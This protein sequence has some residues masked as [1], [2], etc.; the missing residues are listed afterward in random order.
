M[1]MIIDKG[2]FKFI[3]KST[4]HIKNTP[5]YLVTKKNKKNTSINHSIL[6]QT[7]NFYAVSPPHK[8]FTKKKSYFKKH[9]KNDDLKPSKITKKYQKTKK[10]KT[11]RTFEGSLVQ[12][13]IDNNDQEVDDENLFMN[14]NPNSNNSFIVNNNSKTTFDTKFSVQNKSKD[15]ISNEVSKN[16]RSLTPL[17]N[18]INNHY[19]NKA[20]I[21]QL[22]DN[23]LSLEN[24]IIDK[25]YENDIDHDEIIISSNNR[26]KSTDNIYNRNIQNDNNL[27]NMIDNTDINKYLN[28]N[29]E[30]NTNENLLNSSFENHKTDYHLMYV[31]NYQ[32]SVNDDILDLEIKLLYDKSLELQSYYHK[33]LQLLLCSYKENKIILKDVLNNIKYVKKLQNK[34]NVIRIKNTSK[35]IND[36]II[37]FEEKNNFS[38]ITKNN[39]NEIQIWN[40]MLYNKHLRDLFKNIIFEKYNKFKTFLDD[41]G[42]KFIIDL[43]KKYNYKIHIA[44]EKSTPRILNNTKLRNTSDTKILNNKNSHLPVTNANK[45]SNNIRVVNKKKK[46]VFHYYHTKPLQYHVKNIKSK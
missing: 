44:S 26:N 12:S 21:K 1:S 31:Q 20:I 17:P 6:S 23:F 36:S 5:N 11:N 4:D 8:K 2:K 42:N 9:H 32:Q 35:E 3:Y 34:L 18:N 16:E 25:K 43:M 33:Q 10:L 46:K 24:N 41:A 40:F 29:Y 14:V 45:N 7:Q 15:I 38:N 30:D 28:I 39:K 27:Y 13:V 37:F 19:E 22:D